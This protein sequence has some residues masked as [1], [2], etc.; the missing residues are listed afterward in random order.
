MQRVGDVSD[1]VYREV[2][3]ATI[4]EHC[5]NTAALSIEGRDIEDITLVNQTV[6]A[7]GQQNWL[8]ELIAELVTYTID[9]VW[10]ILLD[11][12]CYIGLLLA[13]IC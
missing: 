1:V 6:D 9:N 2:V 4:F 12:V 11:G 10:L 3:V 5:R 7:V 8:K 13:R